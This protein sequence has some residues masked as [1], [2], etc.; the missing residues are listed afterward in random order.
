MGREEIVQRNPK[1]F[2]D[3]NPSNAY[4]YAILTDNEVSK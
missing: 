3:R 2:N 4:L 1:V